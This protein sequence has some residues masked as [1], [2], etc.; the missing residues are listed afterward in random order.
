MANAWV[1]QIFDAKIATTGG[2]IRRK[3]TA[4]ARYASLSVLTGAVKARQF[5]LI[6]MGDQYVILCNTGEMKVLV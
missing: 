1:E 3:K 4:V 6:E 5:H 2:I